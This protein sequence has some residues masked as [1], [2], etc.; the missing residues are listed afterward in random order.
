MVEVRNRRLR[1]T[2]EERGDTYDVGALG[3]EGIGTTDV[4]MGG[5][6]RLKEADEIEAFGLRGER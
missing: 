2:P 5:V 4:Q 6:V 1:G 3:L